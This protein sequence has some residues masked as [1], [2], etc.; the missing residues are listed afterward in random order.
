M[1]EKSV[2][3]RWRDKYVDV[4]NSQILFNENNILNSGIKKESNEKW[5]F[6]L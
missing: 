3:E 4:D 1:K 5:C 6:V 2:H